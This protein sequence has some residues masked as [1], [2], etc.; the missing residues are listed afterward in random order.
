M[1]DAIQKQ[2]EFGTFDIVLMAEHFFGH[3]KWDAPG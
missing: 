2:G 1:S 3:G